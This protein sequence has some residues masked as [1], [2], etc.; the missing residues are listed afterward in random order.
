MSPAR[1]RR[2]VGERVV[3][4]RQ[5]V[6]TGTRLAYAAPL[7]AASSQ[8]DAISIGAQVVSGGGRTIEVPALPEGGATI[9]V[10]AA[11][12]CVSATGNALLCNGDSGRDFCPVTPAGT[13]D[14]CGSYGPQCC[15]YPVCGQLLGRL[16]GGPHFA[17]GAGP[18]CFDT[19][20]AS[21]LTLFVADSFYPD[22]SGSYTA[23][24]TP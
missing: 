13:N 20:G 9:G 1:E 14:V 17:I 22:N 23:T 18:T 2:N 11:E 6:A 8:L 7:I 24:V 5:V 19:S 16:D 15:T 4:R 3:S 12:T 10:A 21:Q